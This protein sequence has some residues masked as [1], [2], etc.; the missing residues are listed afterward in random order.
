MNQV[1]VA[2]IGAGMAGLT[3]AQV[4]Q[5][6][7]Y[8]VVVLE[9]SR[10]VGGRLATRRSHGTRI[11]HGTCYLSPKAELFQ[12]FITDLVQL[13]LVHV[14]TNCVHTLFPDGSLQPSSEQIP[15]YVAADGMSAIAKVLTPGLDIR[16]NQ[17]VV[18]LA[19]TSSQ[20]WQLT[21]DDTTPDNTATASNLLEAQAVV[22]TVPAPQ[23][24]DLLAPLEGTALSE[25][26]IRQLQTVEFAPC[27]A[28]M[29]G[30]PADCLQ[31]WQ[32][33]YADVKAIGS[34]QHPLAWIGLDSSKRRS[35]SQPVF[36]IQSTAD[37]AQPL[38]NATDL[39]PVGR[40]LLQAA[41]DL[42]APWLA[43]PDW[44]QVHRWRYAFAS[45]PLREKYLTANSLTPL[46]CA[47]DWCG[48]IRAESA[49]LSGLE[50]A[51]YL[52][53]KLKNQAIAPTQ[54]WHAIASLK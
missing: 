35:A 16:F 17:R 21:V 43:T 48:G 40:S 7:G 8:E 27:I 9:K 41:A 31:K 37:F 47:G 24:L 49:M 51:S 46:V 29:A 20:T 13:G 28:V 14:W 23:A 38:L 44:L 10:G 32:A 11:D 42:L 12:N 34:Q 2:I 39:I 6:A 22:V 36:V 1:E 52:N 19:T 53:Q 30:Y 25:Q 3:C 33:A 45:S 50:A 18:G 5:Q 4:L 54:F 26:F 15:R